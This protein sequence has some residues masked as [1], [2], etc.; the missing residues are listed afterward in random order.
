[1]VWCV[2]AAVCAAYACYMGTDFFCAPFLFYSL[3]ISRGLSLFVLWRCRCTHSLDCKPRAHFT[4]PTQHSQTWRLH[5]HRW[6]TTRTRAGIL[7]HLFVSRA[8]CTLLPQENP[9]EAFTQQGVT[10]TRTHVPIILRIPQSKHNQHTPPVHV[11]RGCSFC[12]SSFAVSPL[13]SLPL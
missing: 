11:V 1:M 8:L 3:H 9:M 5:R 4:E 2:R 7:L 12:T 13:L 6:A 10:C